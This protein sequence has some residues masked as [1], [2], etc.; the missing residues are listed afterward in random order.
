MNSTNCE[1]PDCNPPSDEIIQCLLKS[2]RIAVVGLSPKESRDSNIV[3]RYLIDQGY[4]VIPINPGQKEIL[5]QKC[6][7]SLLDI[8]LPVDIADLFIN[9]QRVPPVVEQAIEREIPT[10]WMQLGIVNN[11]AAEKARKSGIQVFMD[12]CIKAQHQ[13]NAAELARLKSMESSNPQSFSR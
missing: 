1:L 8:P 6:F 2:K 3:A 13:K 10:I 11:D 5:G 4:E 7:K 9:S 12:L